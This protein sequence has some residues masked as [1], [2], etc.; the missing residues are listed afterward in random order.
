[1]SSAYHEDRLRSIEYLIGKMESQKLMAPVGNRLTCLNVLDFGVGDGGETKQLG[2]QFDSLVGIDVSADM[3]DL[4]SETF[5]TSGFQG[6]VGGVEALSR[7]EEDTI[8]LVL[9]INT[10][11][12]LSQIDRRNFFVEISRVLRSGGFLIITTGNEVFDLFALNS[13]TVEFFERN[14]GVSGVSDLLSEGDSVRF[15]NASRENPLN[16]RNFLT[17]FGLSEIAQSFSQ[18]HHI[19]PIQFTRSGVG[20]NDSRHLARDHDFDPNSLSSEDSWK[21]VFQCSMFGSLS[22]RL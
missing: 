20:L 2:I 19:P 18:W 4:A 14:F 6:I 9:C 17:Q 12:Y 7:L 13:G 1:M 22:V 10:L 8:D 16:F 21:S 3:V 11:G 5:S 15:K